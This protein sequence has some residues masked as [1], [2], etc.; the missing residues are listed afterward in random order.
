MKPDNPKLMKPS[1]PDL[2]VPNP[3]NNGKPLAVNG[4]MINVA[5]KYWRR[6]IKDGDVVAAQ[7]KAKK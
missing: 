1:T 2:I 4:E 5:D 6:R 7:K 3:D